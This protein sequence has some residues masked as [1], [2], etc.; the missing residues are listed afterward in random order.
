MFLKS[1]FIN[2][3]SSMFLTPL[4][5]ELSYG[6]YLI[7]ETIEI[8]IVIKLSLLS[9]VCILSNV[10]NDTTLWYNSGNIK[11]T[12]YG[13]NTIRQQMYLATDVI[14]GSG[15]LSIQRN[16]QDDYTKDVNDL[17]QNSIALEIGDRIH[18]DNINCSRG[19]YNNI[20]I[21]GFTTAVQL[22]TIDTYLMTFKN[23]FLE[24]NRFDFVYGTESIERNNTGENMKFYNC[25]FSQAYNACI[26]NGGGQWAFDNCSFDFCGNFLLINRSCHLTFN[27]CHFEGVGFYQKNIIQAN[28]DNCIGYGTIIYNNYNN[29]SQTS[30]TAI[31]VN[32][33]NFYLG[34][35]DNIIIP[36]YQSTGG[37]GEHPS[38]VINF[39]NLSYF[40]EGGYTYNNVFMNNK[41]VII[42]KF[43]VPMTYGTLPTAPF[44]DRDSI[45]K[46][47]NVIQ[48]NTT[49]KLSQLENYSYSTQNVEENIIIDSS[50]SIFGKSLIFNFDNQQYINIIRDYYSAGCKKIISSLY[51]K[52]EIDDESFDYC[53]IVVRYY[54]YN[55]KGVFTDNQM[56]IYLDKTHSYY[57]SDN[58]WYLTKPS[59]VSIPTGTYR[60]RIAYGMTNRNINGESINTSGKIKFGG[61]ICYPIF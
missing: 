5:L 42:D 32:N 43:D 23:L 36:R 33:P 18:S 30:L 54:F 40:R 48:E 55:T 13:S 34:G 60:I 19:S 29:N 16:T 57:N 12:N 44:N 56:N 61:M 4:K 41:N 27:A 10:S 26:I 45:G 20:S 22:N 53:N 21:S 52:P 6:K 7:S 35:D 46:L 38:L 24:R 15:H 25:V 8:P 3:E 58:G 1:N 2:P 31:E 51:Y 17:T 11:E 50:D 59:I 28:T 14:G 9:D 49:L 37:D 39:R 47:E